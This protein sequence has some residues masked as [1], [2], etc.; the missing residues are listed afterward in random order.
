VGSTSPV[1]ASP[2]RSEL[3]LE[4]SAGRSEFAAS[5]EGSGEGPEFGSEF[6][7]FVPSSNV[8]TASPS[9]SCVAVVLDSETVEVSTPGLS[10]LAVIADKSGFV[11]TER[12]S[13]S[14]MAIVTTV[15]TDAP[16]VF[17]II[18]ILY[19]MPSY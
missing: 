5:F 18:L 17:L 11:I 7:T 14:I 8:N 16:R 12:E 10:A 3:V 19:T 2:P 9:G 4:E 1:V 13:V 15:A 6:K